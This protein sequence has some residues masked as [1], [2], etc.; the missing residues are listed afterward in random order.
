MKMRKFTLA[1]TLMAVLAFNGLAFAN[2][3][4]VGTQAIDYTLPVLNGGEYTLSEQIGQ[5]V[6]MFVVG[7]A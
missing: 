6:I 2:D 7:Y 4:D 1:A 3:G 5:V